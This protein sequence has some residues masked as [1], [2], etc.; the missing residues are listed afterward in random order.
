MKLRLKC[1]YLIRYQHRKVFFLRFE[2]IEQA[3][4]L[5]CQRLDLRATLEGQA[6]KKFSKTQ[7]FEFFDFP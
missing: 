5:Y 1:K 6:R 4:E 2:K 7:F 3:G